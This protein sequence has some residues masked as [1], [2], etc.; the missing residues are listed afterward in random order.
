M[1]EAR[2]FGMGQYGHNNQPVQYS[3][4][5]IEIEI[6]IE[7]EIDSMMRQ[8]E[9]HII[10]RTTLLIICVFMSMSSLRLQVHH[11]LYLFAELGDRETTETSVRR[12]LE[13]GYGTDFYAGG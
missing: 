11:I 9:L 4:S 10:C 6:E 8:R 12:V 3:T 2:A 13:K 7:I 1:T 5:V